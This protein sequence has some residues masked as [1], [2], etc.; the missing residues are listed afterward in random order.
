MGMDKRAL[1]LTPLIFAVFAGAAAAEPTIAPLIAGTYVHDLPANADKY[2]YMSG[3]PPAAGASWAGGVI[4][5]SYN[6]LHRPASLPKTTAIAQIQA[7]MSKWNAAGCNVTFAY[8]GETANG[9][10]TSDRVNVVGWAT[11]DPDVVAPTSGLTYVAWDGTNHFVDADIKINADYSVAYTSGFDATLTHEAGHMLGLN[12]SDVSGQVMSGPPLT[13]YNGMSSLQSDDVAGCVSLYGST[14]APPPGPDVTAPTVPTGLAAS[15]ITQTTLTLTWNASTDPT[16]GGATTSGVANYRIYIGGSFL[17]QVTSAGANVSG[18]APGTSYSFTISA[19]DSAGNCSAQSAPL[20]VSTVGGDTQPP[21]V[22]AGLVATAV[23][24]T[25]IN[26]AWN[27][28]TDNV[29]VT[30]YRVY[31]GAALL[32]SVPGTSASVTNLAPN[33][34]YT[35]TVTACDAAS[36]CSP[37]SNPAS[38]NTQPATCSGPQPP[39]DRQTLACPAGQTGAITQTR[40]YTCVGTTWTPGTYQTIA[41]TC[42]AS[43]PPPPYY[44]NGNYQDLWWAGS[45]ESGWGLTLTQH[46]DALFLAWYIY[47]S[48]GKPM[49]VVLPTGHWNAAHDTY[50]GD[51]Y[52][53]SGSSFATYDPTRFVANASVGTASIRFD[54]A[55]AGTLTYTVR[56]VS[57]SKTITRE[58]FGAVNTAPIASYGDMWW[59][60]AAENGWGLV[61]TQQYH[62]F[63]GA[64]YTYD[65]TGQ[66][67]WYVMPTGTWTSS[68][69]YSGALYRTRGAPVLGTVFNSSAVVATQAGMLTVT[70]TD[71]NTATM[72]YTVDGVT[73]SKPITRIPF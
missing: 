56:G 13:A 14:G 51:L 48:T 55:T 26:L 21:T 64:W 46:G 9:F 42:T 29:G 41:N 28:S 49:W 65:A 32:G 39:D 60:G 7:S 67:M 16:V 45:V 1:F 73:Q 11:G 68:N 4:H 59:G 30:G 37:Q 5:W 10:S 52:I 58:P 34:A 17:G 47:D 54:S 57:G 69:T 27:A 40:S 36:N 63:F 53:P 3:G 70:F 38:A 31:Q 23:S 72:T 2:R 6:D 62:D 50:T 15:S 19:C 25:Q 22:P 33:T 12:H 20:V 44:Q 24:S 71:A 35:F 66:T 61:L 18:L 43:A 8:D